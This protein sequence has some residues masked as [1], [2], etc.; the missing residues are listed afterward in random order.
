MHIEII[1]P[2][3]KI[4][5]GEIESGIFPGSDGFFG[6]QENH[7]PMVATLKE[8]EIKLFTANKEEIFDVKG[9]V[10]EISHNKVIVLAD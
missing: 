6:V 10:L 8:G 4:F 5:S 1:T 7:A 2:D 9:G 3:S